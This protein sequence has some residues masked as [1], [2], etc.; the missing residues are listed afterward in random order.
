MPCP[1]VFGDPA[2]L[3]P[4]IRPATLAQ[5]HD[6]GV[7]PHFREQ[8]EPAVA[9]LRA[10]GVKIIDIMGGVD[11][12]VSDLVTCRA[13]ASSSLHGLV[14]AHA[15]GIPALWVTITD[16]PAG[17]GFKFCDYLDGVAAEQHEP[18]PLAV[19]TTGAELL[20]ACPPLPT[21]DREPLLA[22][23][24]F[25]DSG[26]IAGLASPAALLTAPAPHG[27]VPS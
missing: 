3:F 17:D 19:T 9:R 5:Q 23:C 14:A 10:E 11:R 4:L 16:A 6:L 22:S 20:A 27:G 25:A 7:I 21:I 2:V 8:Q 15:Y 1:D 13:V 12:F 18:F 24:P 26:R